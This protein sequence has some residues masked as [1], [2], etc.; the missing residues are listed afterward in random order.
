[1]AAPLDDLMARVAAQGQRLP[2]MYGRVDF[3]T[4]PERYTESAD[5]RSTL[6]ARQPGAGRRRAQLLAQPET[7]ARIRAYTLLGDPVADAYA[8]L[9]PQHGFRR[10]VDMLVRACDQGLQAVPEAPPELH[11]FIDAMA[12]VPEWLDRGLIERGARIGRSHAAHLSPLVLR[13]AFFATFTNKYAALPMA[14]TG[15][16]SNA[17]AARRVLE[18]ATFFTVSTLPGA[19]ERHGP[20]FK[21]AAMVRLMHSMVRFHALGRPQQWDTKVYGIPIPQVDQMPA[22]LIPAY[23]IARRVV[24]KGRTRFSDR[25]RAQVELA[26]YRCFLLGLPED[27]L[28]D[29]P[30]ALLD[31]MDTRTATLR[32]GF[33]DATCGALLRATMAADLGRDPGWR[34]RLLHA[35]EPSVARLYFVRRFLGGDAGRAAQLGMP[36]QRGDLPRALL[37]V[38]MAAVPMTAHA[39]A[40]RIPGLSGMAD[41]ALVRRLQMLLE[42]YGHAEYQTDAAQYRPAAPHGHAQG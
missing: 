11:A 35:V 26:R 39:V 8:A 34:G 22:G 36:L 33:D 32:D 16:L 27:L 40:R 7:L 10:L 5:V 19:L 18:T 29:T 1:M 4:L 24:Q 30:Q 28:P 17:T 42:R 2:G 41:R 3:G 25:E 21:A 6:E 38:L 15:A 13:G 37:G 9:I 12:R 20:G 14:L 31:I 23:L